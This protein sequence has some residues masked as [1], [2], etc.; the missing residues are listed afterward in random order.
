MSS[1]RVEMSE[2]LSHVC[3]IPLHK[4]RSNTNFVFSD[5]MIILSN[6]LSYD[7]CVH[8]RQS[9]GR[10]M[11]R[12]VARRQTLIHLLNGRSEI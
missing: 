7:V 11:Q 5:A 4:Q 12:G 8:T 10:G 2:I 3:C 6:C 1:D 9:L